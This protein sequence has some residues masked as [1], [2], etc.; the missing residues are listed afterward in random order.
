MLGLE[1]GD[2]TRV[3]CIQGKGPT[4]CVIALLLLEFHF[5]DSQP[6]RKLSHFPNSEANR[7]QGTIPVRGMDET[8]L[9]GG[10][11]N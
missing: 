9:C 3:I 8:C 10:S 5:F 4:H 6:E 7:V 11:Q 1:P 2:Q